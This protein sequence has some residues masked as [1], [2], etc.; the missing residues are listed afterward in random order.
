MKVVVIDD[1]DRS[2]QT[3]V[4]LLNKY[5]PEVTIV[6]ECNSAQDAFVQI[7]LTRPDLIF[8][9]VQMPNASGF[10]LLKKFPSVDF[11]VVFVTAYNQYALQAIKICALDYLL[12][13]VQ[14]D[15][16]IQ[17]VEKAGKRISERDSSKKISQL[18]N[19]LVNK[20]IYT[21]KI[22]LPSGSGL[23]FVPISKIVRCEA[24]GS[25]THIYLDNG[26]RFTTTRSLREYEEML[27]ETQFFRPHNSHIINMEHILKY[28][29]GEGGTVIMSDK[30]TVD[31]AKRR[32]KEFL[33]RF[34]LG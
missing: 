13:P 29:K 9:D 20:N 2:R 7:N 21:A 12:K 19:N 8:L 11:E 22:A 15:E 28:Q 32:K 25:Y 5:C 24:D 34:G 26:Q 3:I 27:P 33:E 14:I 31:I 6:C 30:S 18:L 17:A 23:D 4:Q 16:L 10:D 1:E